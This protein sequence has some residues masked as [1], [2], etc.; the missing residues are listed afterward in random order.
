MTSGIFASTAPLYW[1]VGLNAIPLWAGEK[2][3]AIN[4]W[5]TFASVPIKDREKQSWVQTHRD[6]N[7][8]LALGKQSNVVMIDIDTD[9]PLVLGV[10]QKLLPPSPWT[11]I[12]K[13][14]F[15]LAYRW[16]GEKTFRVKTP[17]GE[18]LVEHLAD[19][20]QCVLPPSIHPDTKKAY[21]SNC[22]LFDPAVLGQLVTLPP[23]F[24]AILRRGL[25]EAGVELSI[26]GHTRV[27]DY[28]SAGS[29]DVQMIA[30]AGHYA[31]GVLRGELTF[32]QALAR[33]VA[34]HSSCVEKVAGD[35]V[36]IHKGIGKLAA[37]VINDVLGP[38]KKSLP[39]GWDAGMSP[40]ERTALG[41]D[42]FTEENIAWDYTRMKKYISA[43]FMLHD[44]DSNGR[45][46]AV[47]YLVDRIANSK[48]DK[49][50]E[51]RLLKYVVAAGG[52]GVSMAPLK[53]L[54]YEQR[55]GGL[56]GSNHAE[57]AEAL[58]KDLTKDGNVA[59]DGGVF[60]Q[61]KG[62]HWEKI[63]NSILRRKVATEF[64]H[65]PAAKKSN[66]F[67]GIITIASDMTSMELKQSSEEG[68]NFANGY[69][70]MDLRLLE[71]SPDFGCTYT[72]PYRY[73]PSESGRAIKFEDF[74][75][76]CWGLDEDF[77]DKKKALQEAL[78]VTMFS[79]A[80]RFERAFCLH[81]PPRSGKS[82]ML[83]IVTALVPHEVVCAVAPEDWSD[84]FLPAQMHGKLLN[85]CGE[86]HEHKNI[87]GKK[88]KEVISGELIT[89]QRKNGQPFEFHPACAHWFASN[90][91]PKTTDTSA[92]FNRRW[93]LLVYNRIVNV[94][95]K[96]L[97]LGVLIAAEEREQ[98]AAWAVEGITRAI[99]AGDYPLP[100]SHE[101]R[102]AEVASTNN[103]IRSFLLSGR[104]MIDTAA[105]NSSAPI[106]EM[107][108]FN[109][110]FTFASTAGVAKPVQLSGFRQKMRELGSELGFGISI[111][112]FSHGGQECHYT[113][114]IP[115]PINLARV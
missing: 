113:K 84:K 72:L 99:M 103:S 75:Y 81:G 78:A 13:K 11:R 49:V 106:P 19:R 55:H 59:F 92:G 24:E 105:T 35:D 39:E 107:T 77:E 53:A 108:L 12:G 7:V 98:I 5:Q 82:Q 76:S 80:P 60:W 25:E 87:D 47:N 61:W 22:N 50:D 43:E 51:D 66:D 10:L 2:R 73:M 69:L 48:I 79:M 67:N 6:G 8:G 85:V 102:I 58:V 110:Y 62:S 38:K 4:E 44:P 91:T 28:V 30:V 1:A 111:K 65:L 74:L 41:F 63:D 86:L 14:G 96:V 90:H 21:V 115:V 104:Y 16:S 9:N 34:W 95:D 88:F 17:K 94:S 45:R 101:E 68:V 54:L 93:L 97:D 3:P 112:S 42:A 32:N 109:A 26:S 57:I 89:G 70:T 71:H 40:A 83:K 36:D 114:L 46:E 100:S 29:R 33:M 31:N 52:L 27:T 64:G 56:S 18:M 23:D 15:V 20:T 37:F